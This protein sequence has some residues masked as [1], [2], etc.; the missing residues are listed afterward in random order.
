MNIENA[1]E[2]TRHLQAVISIQEGEKTPRIA[3][4]RRDDTEI[5]IDSVNRL[6]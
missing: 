5:L 4:T 2:R 6:V 1:L 3:A